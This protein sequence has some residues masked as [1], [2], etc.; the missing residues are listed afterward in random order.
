MFQPYNAPDCLWSRN[1]LK[2]YSK[3]FRLVLAGLTTYKI[4]RQIVSESKQSS[5]W[6]SALYEK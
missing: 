4:F 1:D 3:Y 2:G 6:L 5:N